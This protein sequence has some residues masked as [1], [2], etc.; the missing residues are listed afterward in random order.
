[1]DVRAVLREAGYG[2]LPAGLVGC[3]ARGGHFGGC[4]HDIAVFGG[5]GG[6][7]E[8]VGHGGDVALIRHASLAEADS[9]RLLGFLDLEV[10][11]D[12]SWELRM[13][14]SRIRAKSG[15]LFADAGRGCLVES[16]LCCER[17]RAAAGRDDPFAPFWQKCASC[18]LADALLYLNRT[19][20][21][22]SHALDSLRGQEK[23]PLNEHIGVATGSV[24]IERAT[25]TLLSRMA[26]STAG[27]AKMAGRGAHSDIVRRQHALFVEGSMLAD[28]YFYLC[29]VNRD[30]LA[31]LGGA[32][33]RTRDYDHVLKVAFDA[34]A[35]VQAA[36]GASA[37]IEASCKAILG[38]MSGA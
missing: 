25:P 22:P 21:G 3:R 1:M 28:C 31:G 33:G 8:A 34:E 13:M 5:K 26:E 29:Y 16:L 17:A 2:G 36:L 9:G 35:G 14:A 38:A 12:E 18:Y 19:V 6:A 23:S 30:S 10:I 37:E 24:G 32:A 7:D 27:F 11:Q 20:P 4:A 15:R